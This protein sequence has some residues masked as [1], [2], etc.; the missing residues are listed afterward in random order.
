M[1][2][3]D[4][5][6]LVWLA[7]VGLVTVVGFLSGRT[8]AALDMGIFLGPIGLLMAILMISRDRKRLSERSPIVQVDSADVRLD[9]ADRKLSAATVC[10]RR[11]A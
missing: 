5:V 8:A 1:S 9:S 6:V 4:A 10:L 3:F 7:S 11:A 2:I